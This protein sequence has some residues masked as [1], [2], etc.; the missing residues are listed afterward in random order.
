MGLEE[1]VICKAEL[2]GNE[3]EGDTSIKLIVKDAK[4][5]TD[6]RPKGQEAKVKQRPGDELFLHEDNFVG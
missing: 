4:V 6:G 5:E 1:K 3:N 2:D